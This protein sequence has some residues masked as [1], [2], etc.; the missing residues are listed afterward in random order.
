MWCLSGG[1]C[2]ERDKVPTLFRRTG[3]NRGLGIILKSIRGAGGSPVLSFQDRLLLYLET[4]PNS[5]L[6]GFFNV[7]AFLAS[8]AAFLTSVL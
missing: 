4:K 3:D 6:T 5:F 1:S 2:P 7:V 8:Q